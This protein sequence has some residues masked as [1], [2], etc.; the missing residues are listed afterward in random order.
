MPGRGNG[1]ASTDF[2]DLLDVKIL[3]LASDAVRRQRL[4]EREGSIGDWE[5]Q[6]HE[7]EEW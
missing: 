7:A 4:T 5:C 1:C 6:W 2:A 3:V